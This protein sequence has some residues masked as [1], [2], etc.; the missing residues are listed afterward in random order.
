MA[1]EITVCPQCAA[2]NRTSSHPKK[3]PVCGRCKAALPW[4]VNAS[5]GS[6]DDEIGA[7]APV[8]VDLWAPWCGPCRVMAPALEE[9]ARDVAG[10]LKVVKVNV[11]ENPRTQGRFQVQGIPT[12]LLFSQGKVVEKIVGAQTKAALAKLVGPHL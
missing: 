1:T 11:D 12:L 7:S 3:M 8:L 9:L 2:K 5:D 10:R 4:M 6:F